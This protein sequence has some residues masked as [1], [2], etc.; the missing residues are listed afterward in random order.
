MFGETKR[1]G[2]VQTKPVEPWR[3]LLLDAANYIEEHGWCRTLMRGDAVCARGAMLAVVGL[4]HD[5]NSYIIHNRDPRF[6]AA[7]ERLT[8]FLRQRDRNFLDVGCWNNV[9]TSAEPVIAAMR[10]CANSG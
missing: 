7:D 6:A 9:Q 8:K 2:E 10:D 1:E 4:L 3:S 5:Q